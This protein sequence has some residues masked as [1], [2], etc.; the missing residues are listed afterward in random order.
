MKQKH[1]T[2]GTALYERSPTSCLVFSTD[3]QSLAWRLLIVTAYQYIALVCLATKM[4]KQPE[5]HKDDTYPK[6]QW[7]ISREW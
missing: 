7:N 4:Q 3:A 5:N 2:G 6:Q 1:N